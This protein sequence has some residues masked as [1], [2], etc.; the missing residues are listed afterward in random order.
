[1]EISVHTGPA[2]SEVIDQA[3]KLDGWVP[4]EFSADVVLTVVPL[5]KEE[6]LSTKQ[7]K[8]ALTALRNSPTRGRR[9]VLFGWG[10]TGPL[11]GAPDTT[12]RVADSLTTLTPAITLCSLHGR[13]DMEEQGSI[14]IF[15]VTL[16]ELHC[17]V[18]VVSALPASA[19]PAA[20]VELKGRSHSVGVP[21]LTAES[22]QAMFLRITPDLAITK[23][24]SVVRA[25]G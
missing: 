23:A 8:V 12:T 24:L 11:L 19:P 1:M 20:V 3:S 9:L 10:K 4:V 6:K 15:K 25:L 17:L 13:G 14:G 22:I 7:L 18:F 16:G 2:A 21:T 5:K